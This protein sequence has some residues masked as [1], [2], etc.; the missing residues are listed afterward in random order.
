M[1]EVRKPLFLSARVIAPSP[2]DD[3]APDLALEIAAANNGTRAVELSAAFLTR[4]PGNDVE[5]SRHLDQELEGQGISVYFAAGGCCT[6]EVQLCTATR[7]A[8][9]PDQSAVFPISPAPESRKGIVTPPA[10]VSQSVTGV[11]QRPTAP[12]DAARGVSVGDRI[13]QL[14]AE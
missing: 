11:L 14:A 1:L 13:R 5:L 12:D 7:D 3:V 9:A 8:A 2:P 6:W 10:P 4:R